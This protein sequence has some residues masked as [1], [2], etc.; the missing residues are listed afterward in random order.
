MKE[1]RGIQDIGI[2]QNETFV[3]VIGWEGV[4]EVSSFGYV[5]NVERFTSNNLKVLP[6]IKK[7]EIVDGGY[8]RITLVKRPKIERKMLSR[9]I[10]EH[11]I[12]NP[13]NKPE[14]NH[15]DGNKLNNHVSNLEWVTKKENCKHAYNYGLKGNK[16]PR[17]KL[18]NKVVLSIYNEQTSLNKISIKY[19]LPKLTIQSIKSG[20]RYSSV[21]GKQYFG[22][23]Y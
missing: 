4:Y 16:I 3:P 15:K 1:G 12:P 19:N 8:M 11:F 18:S 6:T 7:C 23:K 17:K 21:T 2:Y 20:K 10:A 9:L 13:Q 22:K 5:R 14:V